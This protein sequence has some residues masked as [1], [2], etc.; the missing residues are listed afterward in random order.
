M[1]FSRLYTNYRMACMALAAI[2][3]S[4]CEYDGNPNKLDDVN[5]SDYAGKIDGYASSEEIFPNNLI[6][7]WSFDDTKNELVSGT[8]PTSSANDSFV[9]GGVR[10]K[11]LNLN[12]GYVYFA[13]Q[14]EK[15]KT[16]ALKSFTI[17]QWVQVQN[18]G[19]TRTMSF[20]LARP[21]M[22]NGNINLILN[23]QLNP[24]ENQ[25][26]LRIQPTFMTAT[27]GFQDN[28]NNLL[29]PNIEAGKWTHIVLTYDHTSGVFNI[30]ADGVKVGNFPNRGLVNVFYAHEPSEVII[31]SN[32]NG[33]PG[34]EVN[35]DAAFAPMTGRV[36][37]I[38]V[39]NIPLP[40]AHIRSLYNLGRANL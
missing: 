31:G 32:Y 14:F 24:A 19:S 37:E 5:P 26:I 38:R 16:D 34:K 25:G 6:A 3:L 36:D 35:T 23:T 40:D 2:V 4:S 13:H 7:Y 39:F 12:R 27:G 10:G 8:A 33:I 21:G 17:S 22:Q 20:Q 15:F 18:N 28:L 11:A 30:W 9:D 29:S 1:K